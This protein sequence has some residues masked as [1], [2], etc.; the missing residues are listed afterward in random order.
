MRTILTAITLSLVI[1]GSAQAQAILSAGSL[2]AGSTQ[3]RAV[4]YFYNSGTSNLTLTSPQI[5]NSAGGAQTLV[6]NECGATLLAG[7]S[8][9]IAANVANTLP[10]NCRVTVSPGKGA[11]RGVFEMRNSSGTS[12]TNV[13]LR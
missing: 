8:C 2:F 9:G 11:A 7:A 5:T 6:V 12:L 3:F 10:Y 4:C 1:A 13:E